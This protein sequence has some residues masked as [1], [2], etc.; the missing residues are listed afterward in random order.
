MAKKRPK[1]GDVLEIAAAGGRVYVQVLDRHPE[2]GDGI[3]VC[4]TPLAE[5]PALTA[6]LFTEGYVTFYPATLAVARGF[7]EVIGTLPSQGCRAGS[8]ARAPLRRTVRW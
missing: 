1:P 3:L 2:Y 8:A 5:R 7:A 6:E 4:P